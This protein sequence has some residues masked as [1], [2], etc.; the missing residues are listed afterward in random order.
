MVMAHPYFRRGHYK[1]ANFAPRFIDL[2]WNFKSANCEKY[3]AI[4][5][6]RV[7]INVNNNMYL[8]FDT[9]YGAKFKSTMNDIEDGIVKLRPPLQL[10]STDIDFFWPYIFSRYKMEF[11]RRN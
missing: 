5:N 1:A 4:D 6:H 8:E 7:R 3:I 2:F 11:K 10:Q 9:G